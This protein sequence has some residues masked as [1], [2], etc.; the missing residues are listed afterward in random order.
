MV[1]NLFKKIATSANRTFSKSNL[2]KV[3]TGLTKGLHSVS[4][5]L[6]KIGSVGSQILNNPLTQMAASAIGG[7]EVGMAMNLVGKGLSAAKKG[8]ALASSA[9][10]I[11]NPSN[12]KGS[13]LQNSQDAVKRIQ[14]LQDQA[15]Q[16]IAQFA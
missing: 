5:V 2:Q 10:N 13:V 15:A 3:G 11:T 9:A 1:Y 16:P 14:A 4:D 7:P 6:G 12:Y 8:S